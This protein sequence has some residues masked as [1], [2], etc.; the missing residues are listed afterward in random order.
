MSTTARSPQMH[1]EFWRPAD[2]GGSTT[3]AFE[4]QN[5]PNCQAEFSIGARYC[6]VCGADR[7]PRAAARRFAALKRYLNWQLFCAWIGLNTAAAI[8]FV[9]GIVC[10]ISTLLVGALYQA[11]TTL[12][13]Q[14]IQTW[15]MQWLLAASA[16][17][18]AGILL[19]KEAK[20]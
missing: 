13:W 11:Q 18:L 10:V 15:R 20:H 17:F 2:A 6:H 5:C 14:A 7:N 19:R 1:T 16:A 12:E 3:H 9:A 8:A 4:R